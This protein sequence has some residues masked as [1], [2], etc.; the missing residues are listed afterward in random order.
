M[1]EWWVILF[2]L[3]VGWFVLDM[4]ARIYLMYHPGEDYKESQTEDEDRAYRK[5][6]EAEAVEKLSQ[7]RW[8]RWLLNQRGK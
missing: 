8:G 5:K 2:A 7:Y 4:S 1:P 6:K 3:I